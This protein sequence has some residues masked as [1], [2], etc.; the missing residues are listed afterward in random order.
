MK[1]LKLRIRD[2]HCKVLDQLASEVEYTIDGDQVII[3]REC[4]KEKKY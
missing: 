4:F 2:R 1:T 3:C